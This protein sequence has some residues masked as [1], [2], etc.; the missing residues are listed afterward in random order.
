M[1]A[2]SIGSQG[3]KG[4]NETGLGT[5]EKRV[6]KFKRIGKAQRQAN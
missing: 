5:N 3:G 1:E 4:L 2:T 6:R